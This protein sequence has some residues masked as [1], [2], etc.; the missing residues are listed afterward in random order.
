[1]MR[2]KVFFPP[3]GNNDYDWNNSTTVK[4]YCNEW[5]CRLQ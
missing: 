5:Q 1:M 4:S 3:N 2:E